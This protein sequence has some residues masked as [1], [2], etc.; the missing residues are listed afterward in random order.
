M[1][2]AVGQWETQEGQEGQGV[3]WTLDPGLDELHQESPV[4]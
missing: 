2:K 3:H 1:A 4:C